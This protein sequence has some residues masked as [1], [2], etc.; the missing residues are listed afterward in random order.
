MNVPSL[1]HLRR[2]AAMWARMSHLQAERLREA[3]DDYERARLDTSIRRWWV[4]SR[5]PESTNSWNLCVE[6]CLRVLSPE[7]IW[8]VG[9]ERHAF[10]N[11]ASQLVKCVKR[12]PGGEAPEPGDVRILSL[13][14]NVE[15]HWEDPTGP[16]M[17][18]LLDMNPD[19]RLGQ[20]WTTTNEVWFEDVSLSAIEEWIGAV[21]AAVRAAAAVEGRPLLE[22]HESVMEDQEPCLRHGLDDRTY[23]CTCNR[24]P[25]PGTFRGKPFIGYVTVIDEM[26]KDGEVDAAITLIEEIIQETEE[27]DRLYRHGVTEGFYVRL[28]GI[29]RARGESD[30]E[31]RVWKRLAAQLRGHWPDRDED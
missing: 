30:K 27:Q 3:A 11:A 1:D 15:V 9:T 31:A 8:R 5:D 10:L 26:L 18:A 20:F 7:V 28:A 17:R 23:V 14:R 2:M 21:D 4:G 13:L 22:P 16:S 19:F 29:Y 24:R 12:L 6:D 25:A